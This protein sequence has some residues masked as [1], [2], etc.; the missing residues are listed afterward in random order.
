MGVVRMDIQTI[1]VSGGPVSSLVVL[2]P[3]RN[4]GRSSVQL[5]IRIGPVESAAISMGVDG[6]PHERPLTHDLL[7]TIISSLGGRVSRVVISEVRGTTFYAKVEIVTGEGTTV[8][9]DARPSDA[10]AIAVRTQA[11]VYADEKVLDTAAL[12]DFKGVERDE[13][14]HEMELFHDFVEN[15]SPDDFSEANSDIGRSPHDAPGE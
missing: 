13:E 12:P 8:E 5:P 3:H 11:P 6:T 4:R 7:C 14:R 15:L 2:R 1:V 9:V 10:I